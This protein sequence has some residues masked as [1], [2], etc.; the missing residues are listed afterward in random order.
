MGERVVFRFYFCFGFFGV[1]VRLAVV[2]VRLGVC[3][4]V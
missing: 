3:W 2:F 1:M 4:E